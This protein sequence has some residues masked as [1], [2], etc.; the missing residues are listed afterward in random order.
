LVGGDSANPDTTSTFRIS[1][2]NE[3]RVGINVGDG[4]LDRALV[5]AGT[6]RI[7]GDFRFESDIDVNGGDI[8]STS[9]IFT[10]ANQS[11]TTTLSL[12]GYATTVNVGNLAT[13][14]QTVNIGTAVTGATTLNIHSNSTNSTIDIGTVANDDTA[15][16]SNITF[17]GAFLNRQSS[18]FNIKN[19][20]TILD[21]VLTIN[22]GEIN[23]T[24]LND[25]FTL[26]P[27]GITKLN[28][29]LSVGTLTL[30]GVAGTTTIRNGLRVLGSSF[31]ESD[32][33][34]NGGLK[35]TNLGIDRNIFGTIRIA[36]LS[37][38]NGV[39]TVTTIAPHNISTTA[40]IVS[41]VD[42][43]N[44]VGKVAVTVTG[45]NTFT[46]PN[47][48]INYP[49]AVATGTVITNVGI[50]QSVGSLA[51]L[52]I[53]YFSVISNFDGTV[54]IDTVVDNKLLTD[55]YWFSQNDA[56]Q[57]FDIGNL[58]GVSTNVTY[59]V[60]SRD[61]TGFTLKNS[62]DNSIVIGLQ[63]G[64]TDA[65]NARMRLFSTVIDTTG[66]VPW[67]DNSFKNR[68]LNGIQ[69]WNLPINN[70]TGISIN[71]LY[72]IGEEIIQTVNFPSAFV[73]NNPQPFFVE[74]IRAQ[75]GTAAVSHPDGQRIYR[76]VEQQNASY[77]F[78]SPLTAVDSAINVAEFSANIRINDLFRLN[79][80]KFK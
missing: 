64:T 34:Q 54:N 24:S 66:D 60:E 1:T 78:P 38:S 48:G 16:S 40:Q 69:T 47:P 49:Q 6:G 70:P 61:S 12:A 10:L 59:Y 73:P 2:N 15:Y 77:I 7:T 28:I 68:I 29:G 62:S 8:R 63:S 80:S 45:P 35:N 41:S 19:Y 46:Y 21:G 9:A 37:R 33:T 67:G 55:N 44:T 17:G 25:E 51:N 58:T 31:F 43:F 20:R 39:A 14:Q 30:G 76:L 79:K 3:G 50:T 65:G 13:T 57:F 22:G 11:S 75:R 32:I 72:L 52:N 27:S 4:G 74:V 36:T 26:F 5:V 56:V 18:F 42:S 23:T 53:D 71:Q